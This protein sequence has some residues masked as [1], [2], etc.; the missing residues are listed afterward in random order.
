MRED[1]RLKTSLWV[2]AVLRQANATGCPA[3]RRRRGDEDAGGV[4]AVLTDRERRVIVLSQ[5][6]TPDGA[7]AWIRAT[8]VEPVTEQEADSYIERQVGRDPDLWV[9]EFET[10]KLDPPFEAVLL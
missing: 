9:L 2:S 7:P 4:L 5:T 10:E 8:G 1:A 6:R 3:F